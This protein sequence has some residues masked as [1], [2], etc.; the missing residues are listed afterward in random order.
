MRFFNSILLISALTLLA[1][2]VLLVAVIIGTIISELL[3]PL[4]ELGRLE[5]P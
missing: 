5:I 2:L 4:A 1:L 3:Y